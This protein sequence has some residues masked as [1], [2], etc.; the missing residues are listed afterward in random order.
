MYRLTENDACGDIYRHAQ[1]ERLVRASSSLCFAAAFLSLSLSISWQLPELRGILFLLSR[2]LNT[3][4]RQLRSANATQ[5]ETDASM[6]RS[7]LYLFR[8]FRSIHGSGGCIATDAAARLHI[9]RLRESVGSHTATPAASSTTTSLLVH[10]PEM[11][12][13]THSKIASKWKRTV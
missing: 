5:E 9:P 7:R 10:L 13:F 1:R 8:K 12:F 11:Y 3:T 4:H 2:S 6:K